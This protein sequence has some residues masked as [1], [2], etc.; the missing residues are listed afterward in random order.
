MADQANGM[1]EAAAR[2][3]PG[4]HPEVEVLVRFHH[5]RV[6]DH[7][8]DAI[9]EHLSLCSHCAEL[10]LDL[11]NFEDVSFEDTAS[12]GESHGAAEDSHVSEDNVVNLAAEVEWRKLQ[13]RLDKEGRVDE[14]RAIPA[15]RRR[16]VWLAY[17][18][19]AGFFAM[20]VGLGLWA[21][22]LRSALTTLDAPQVNVQ[23]VNLRPVGSLRSGDGVVATR[24][25]ALPGER[26][27]VILN[28]SGLPS[29]IEHR[30]TL[31]RD[32]QEIWQGEGLRPS[33]SEN[34]YV[35]LPRSL[36]TPGRYT[37]TLAPSHGAMPDE[38]TEFALEIE[39]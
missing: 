23:I 4:I 6:P 1:D 31:L 18:V 11:V 36:L 3:D 13:S 34:F 39:P 20:A 5:G 26:I 2:L 33:E 25:A 17:G 15:A 22:T 21:L 19:A 7:E 8:A 14:P 28:P 32:G 30:V 10:L 27:V 38:A 35:S 29:D 12:A 37:L 16:Q 24:S 9:A